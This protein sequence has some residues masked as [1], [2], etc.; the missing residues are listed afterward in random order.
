[1]PTVPEERLKGNYG[2]SVVMARLSSQCLV[3]P[4]AADTDVGVDLY[5]ETV[6]K[7][8]PFLH[9]WVQVK[10]G[11]QCQLEPPT[12]TGPAASCRF[13]RDHLDYWK[14]QPVPV[15]AALVPTDWP[16]RT[17]PDIYVID[18]TAQ[19]LIAD[20]H[21]TT[22]YPILRSDYHWPAGAQD[23]VRDFLTEMVPA[24]TAR[25]ECFHGVVAS[26]PTPT[27]QYVREFPAVPVTQFKTKI[28]DQL[29][30]TAAFSILYSVKSGDSTPEDKAFR[31]RLAR[32]VEQFVG[33]RHYENFWSRACSS[34]ADGNYELAKALY[35]QAIQCILDDPR[36]RPLAAFPEWKERLKFIQSEQDRARSGKPPSWLATRGNS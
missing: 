35:E 11:A 2:A 29:R 32:I 16:V 33:D 1:M 22:Q 9:F 6:A 4:V 21:D 20:P 3:R 30:A 7:G 17:E 28:L 34:H 12:F 15:Y 19:L 26:S 14:Q 25:L 18:I 13:K 24:T 31:R 23:R 36:L 10:T 27:P 8:Q 5:C